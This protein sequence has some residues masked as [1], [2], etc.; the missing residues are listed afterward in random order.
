[1]LFNIPV[2]PKEKKKVYVNIWH[3]IKNA[4]LNTLILILYALEIAGFL[5]SLWAYYMYPCTYNLL[6]LIGYLIFFIIR[7][8]VRRMVRVSY[9][10]G[11]VTDGLGRP[12]KGLEIGLFDADFEVMVSHTFTDS[13]GR[14]NFIVQ[15]GNYYVM[16]I[17]SKYKIRSDG[18]K[19]YIS[20]KT[21][22]FMGHNLMIIRKS[23]KVAKKF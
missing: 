9:W 16:V 23:F 4:I 18:G 6:V 13:D 3:K 21:H 14:Y 22:T 17:D 20:R 12:I 10:T 7:I 8:Y 19:L 5:Y 11:R 1:M 15:E 2:D